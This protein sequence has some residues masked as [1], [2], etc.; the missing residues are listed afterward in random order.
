MT[1]LL[2]KVFAGQLQLRAK[3]GNEQGTGSGG[4]CKKLGHFLEHGTLANHQIVSTR[5]NMSGDKKEQ[6]LLNEPIYFQ[7]Q[8]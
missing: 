2:P 4:K 3:E 5:L 8:D 1:M 7:R 6:I